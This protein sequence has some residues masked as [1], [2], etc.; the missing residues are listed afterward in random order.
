[1][2]GVP[3]A[4]GM[5][6]IA[7]GGGKIFYVDSENGADGNSGRDPD[8]ALLTVEAAKA[9]MTTNKN[10][11]M[12]LIGR[13]TSYGLAAVVDWSLSYSHIV[14]ATPPLGIGQRARITASTT[15]DLGIMWTVSGNGNSFTNVQFNNES[16][17]SATTGTVYMTG[18]RNYFENCYIAGINASGPAAAAGSYCLS[19]DGAREF[20]FR[21]CVIGSTTYARGAANYTLKMS[22]S[23]GTFRDCKIRKWDETSARSMILFTS[24]SG[25]S[26]DTYFI[27]C[28]FYN[29]SM[30]N[31]YPC[32]NVFDIAANPTTYYIILKNCTAVNCTGWGNDSGGTGED[33]IY[34][35]GAAPTN[36][37][38]GI[39]VK[40]TS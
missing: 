6:T 29:F 39:A 40:A 13:A 15:V 17:A 35:D 21:N 7:L 22:G 12:V 38:S 20:E 34:I 4:W 25:S 24:P 5:D 2:G 23:D 8:S 28:I 33:R 10:D 27:D 16:D 19:L 18:D 14:G 31:V 37:T 26:W 3:T 9:V 36:S 30:D 11:I 1:M 32:T